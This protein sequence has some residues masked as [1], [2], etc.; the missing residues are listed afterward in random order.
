MVPAQSLIAVPIE[1]FR[2]VTRDISFDVYLKLSEENVVH[3]F[4][5]STG[6]DYKRLASY[7]QKG[8]TFL[9]IREED[10]EAYKA[11]I[12]RTFDAIIGDPQATQ[13]KKIAALLN[14]TEQNMSEVFSQATVREETI[15]DTQRLVSNY[16]DLMAN[17]PQSLP[18]ILKLVSHG[19]YLYYH[20]I[21]VTIF[22]LFIAKASGRFNR[23]TLE[24]LG[25]GAFLHDIGQTRLPRDMFDTSAKLTPEERDLMNQHP[26]LGLEMLQGAANVPDEVRYIVYQHHE[27]PSGKGYPNGLAGDAIYYPVRVV[28][29]ADSFSALVSKRPFRSAY[30]VEEAIAIL[31][32]NKEKFDQDLVELLAAIILRHDG[33]SRSAA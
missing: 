5:R 23:E 21:A 25:M 9:Y 18:L 29:L 30:P 8:V 22:S 27:E 10:E 6:L 26:K 1:N 4:S 28:S 3:V 20:S 32:S 12:S 24:V 7:L 15:E 13:E 14:M 16:V 31:R 17:S 19:E 2:R 11:Y 33:R